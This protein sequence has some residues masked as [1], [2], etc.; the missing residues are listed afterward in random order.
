M[1]TELPVPVHPS[2]LQPVAAQATDAL[3]GSDA[4]MRTSPS[5]HLALR[6]PAGA[7]VEMLLPDGTDA[8]DSIHETWDRIM[9]LSDSV[10][11]GKLRGA[12]GK[13]SERCSRGRYEACPS[14]DLSSYTMR[15]GETT[16][17]SLAAMEG[18]TSEHSH[19][20]IKSV[21]ADGA[22]R[23][24]GRSGRSSSYKE[25]YSRRLGFVPSVDPAAAVEVI[26]DLKPGSTYVVTIVGGKR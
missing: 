4:T 6:A 24:A 22:S 18:L 13:V 16:D 19:S 15:F 14:L 23:L 1:S 5:M 2:D 3:R 12:S 8:L 26:S 10:R 25:S 7:G 9:R 21:A 11:R 17:A 20:T